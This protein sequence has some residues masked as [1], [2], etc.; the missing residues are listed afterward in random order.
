[1]I[2]RTRTKGGWTDSSTKM[3]DYD[4][5]CSDVSERLIASPRKF[6]T[7]DF[8]STND[9][10][11]PGY[12]ARKAKG[13]VFFN[14]YSSA[15]R[16]VTLVSGAPLDYRR[17]NI[18]TCSAPLRYYRVKLNDAV[19][20]MYGTAVGVDRSVYPLLPPDIDLLGHSVMSDLISEASTS[21][22]SERG[23]SKDGNLWET[24]AESDK[25]LG[26]LTGIFVQTRKALLSR[27]LKSFTRESSSGYL[28]YRY[29][30]KP[31]MKDVQMVIDGL[32][33]DTGRVRRTTRESVDARE[34][35]LQSLPYVVPE[36][37]ASF[38]LN[39][40]DEATVRAM[41]LDEYFN[42]TLNNIGISTKG[43]ITLPWE[44]L[45]F[46]F[47]LDWFVNA[48]ELLGSMVPAIGWTQL[49]SCYTVSRKRTLQVNLL[50]INPGTGFAINTA[51]S[52]SLLME[53]DTKTR[54]PGLAPGQLVIK[55]D[56]RFSKL[57]RCLD[58]LSLLSVTMTGS[59]LPV[60]KG[61]RNAKL[62]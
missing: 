62:F 40:T 59:D 58:A 46:S 8:T 28:G 22:N 39:C 52:D 15:R 48:G 25:A 29:G 18:S 43:L 36:F 47:V 3:W 42:S 17:I 21:V 32:Q 45:R 55:S 60:R 10:L 37:S 14:P 44:L 13:E 38:M 27:N 16:Q 31:L 51:P 11:V 41:S 19:Q 54:I 49:G 24:L 1:M 12:H 20:H 26:A 5:S 53:Y 2:P 9:V 35:R 34:S 57:T 33:A 56:F 4:R 50:S 6:S 30:L 23:R 7:G 61:Y